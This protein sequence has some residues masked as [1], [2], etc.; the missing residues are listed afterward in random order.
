VISNEELTGEKLDSVLKEL[1]GYPES[2]ARM[3]ENMGTIY[4]DKAEELIV[5]GIQGHVS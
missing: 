3:A 4:V 5:K 1:Y 2:R